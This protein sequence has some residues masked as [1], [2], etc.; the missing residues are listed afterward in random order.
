MKSEYRDVHSTNSAWMHTLSSGKFN[1]LTFVAIEK[2]RAAALFR[3][4][5]KVP[6]NFNPCLCLCFF[7]LLLIIIDKFAWFQIPY[8]VKSKNFLFIIKAKITDSV[9]QPA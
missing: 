2:I 6:Y 5:R 4:S 9:L 7:S 3:N 1:I 8:Y